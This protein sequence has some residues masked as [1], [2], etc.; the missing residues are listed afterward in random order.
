[1]SNFSLMSPKIMTVEKPDKPGLPEVLDVTGTSVH[2]QWTAPQSNGGADITEYSV[3]YWISESVEYIRV[4]VDVNIESV[5]S[6]TIRNK[7]Q[8]HRMYKF[9]VAAVNR[10]GQGL[11]SDMVEDITTYAGM[12]SNIN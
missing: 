12:L 3:L 9:A 2:L 1:M 8:A 7:L 4:S 10:V 5:I 6:Y 11:W